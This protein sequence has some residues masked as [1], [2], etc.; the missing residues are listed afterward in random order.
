MP[1][2]I[3]A[4]PGDVCRNSATFLATHCTSAAPD[5]IRINPGW[6]HGTEALPLEPLKKTQQIDCKHL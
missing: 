1:I 3:S 4:L 5:I 6:E 2:Y